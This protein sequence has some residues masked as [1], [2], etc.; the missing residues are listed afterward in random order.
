[1]FIIFLF[2]IDFFCL[3]G[4]QDPSRVCK[5]HHSSWQ[6]RVLNPLME[7]RDRTH[8][9]MVTSWICFR[10]TTWELPIFIIYCFLISMW[11]FRNNSGYCLLHAMRCT[12]VFSTLKVIFTGKGQM[13]HFF[14]R[15]SALCTYNHCNT[16]TIV[17]FVFLL[18]ACFEFLFFLLGHNPGNKIYV[19][20]I[21]VL[22]CLLT[23]FSAC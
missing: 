11:S 15:L 19:L 7:A 4:L 23:I 2:C 14:C 12:T 9:L 13:W 6:R 22:Q 21:F 20:W 10:C 18:L 16:Y 5:P 1:M 17:S 8:D 3:L